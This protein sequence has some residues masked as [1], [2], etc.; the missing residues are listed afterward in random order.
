MRTKIK[1]MKQKK[2]TVNTAQIRFPSHS[3]N[4]ALARSFVSAF[5]YQADP[6]V[7]EISDLKCAVSEAVT[8][9]IVHGYVNTVGT[10]SV[11]CRMTDTYEVTVTVEDKGRGIENVEEAMTPMFT[12]NT[13]GERTGMGFTVMKTFTDKIKVSSKPGRGTKV[14]LVKK[15]DRS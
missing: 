13:D 14:T 15:L 11:K 8:N 3:Q 7:E 1:Q 10:V 5:I 2:K 9:S 6:T 12:T 4:E